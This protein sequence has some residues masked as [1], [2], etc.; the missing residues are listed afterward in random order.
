MTES[1]KAKEQLITELASNLVD[2]LLVDHSIKT[3]PVEEAFRSVP[4]HLFVDRYYNKDRLVKVDAQ[5]PTPAQLRRIYS[6]DALVSHRRRRIPTSSTSQPSLVAQML[7]ELLLEPGQKI[8]E[9]G[10]GTGWNAALMGHIVGLKGCVYSVD[11]QKDV[12]QR[13]QNHIRRL[14]C[15]NVEIVTGDGGYGYPKMA[16]YDKIVTTANCPEISPHWMEQLVERGALLISLR[17][18]EGSS[19]CLLMR[20]WKRKDHLSGEVVST[21]GFMVLQGDYG[22]ALF[23]PNAE[24]RLKAGRHPRSKDVPL[25]D[26]SLHPNSR[27]WMLDQLMFFAYLEGMSVERVGTRY[28]L[29]SKG[30]DSVCMTDHE[31]TEIYGSDDSYQALEGITRR[32]IELGAPWRT[33]Y[34]VEVWPLDIPKRKPKDG[35]LVKRKHSQLIFRLKKGH[36]Q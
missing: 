35:W 34:T 8:L 1:K 10:A 3:K 7:E 14:G 5:N 22:A 23:H 25:K 18:M 4:R 15:R 20:L 27:R 36:S 32:W 33:Y 6:N 24:E 21:P 30:L 2:L 29:C 28:I 16:P 12:A 13:A 26:L 31:K 9:I 17:D 19:W 11:I